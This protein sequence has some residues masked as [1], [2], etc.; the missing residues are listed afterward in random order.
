LH[1][2][3]DLNTIDSIY[4][5]LNSF[6][7]AKNFLGLIEKSKILLDYLKLSFLNI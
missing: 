1:S 2:V 7:F 6:E 4:E 5:P 3:D